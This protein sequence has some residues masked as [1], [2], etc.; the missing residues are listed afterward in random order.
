[1][2]NL[3]NGGVSPA[4]IVVQEAVE[5]YNEL[6]NEGPSYYMW[7]ILDQGREPLREKLARP[8][9]REAGGDC[10][11]PQLDRGA[12][13]DHLWA[14]AEGRRRGDRDEAGLPAT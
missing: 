9:G 4:P 11:R 10:D 5:R 1:M 13:H 7:Q 14:A 3:N 6:T 8:G 12:E 2:I